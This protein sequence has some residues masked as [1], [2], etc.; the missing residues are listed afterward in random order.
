MIKEGRKSKT[1]NGTN[2]FRMVIYPTEDSIIYNRS[3]TIAE[4]LEFFCVF[5][6]SF[7][8]KT[9]IET[10]A[11]DYYSDNDQYKD[12]DVNEDFLDNMFSNNG[13][14][15]QFEY[16]FMGNGSGGAIRDSLGHGITLPFNTFFASEGETL[17]KT[18]YF[19]FKNKL[20]TANNNKS[21]LYTEPISVGFLFCLSP[22]YDKVF[23]DKNVVSNITN[24]QLSGPDIKRLMFK[25]ADMA[26]IGY[27]PDAME[28]QLLLYN[29][30]KAVKTIEKVD[31]MESI[32][33]F[34]V[35]ASRIKE[36]AV[37]KFFSSRFSV[38]NSLLT[39]FGE[40]PTGSYAMKIQV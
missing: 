36:H 25:I 35:L 10:F 6:L 1:E 18:L 9:M 29:S 7:D 40:T 15:K 32:D 20:A 17:S 24:S 3:S 33:K 39:T 28:E 30:Q 19:K 14:V 4:S 38:F 37:R 2:V 23:M 26:I 16:E 11:I 5:S 34:E 22:M 8:I 27:E 31:I 12:A 21:S 13:L